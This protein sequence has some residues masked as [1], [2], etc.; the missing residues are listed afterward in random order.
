[1]KERKWIVEKVNRVYVSIC[2][3][4]VFLNDGFDTFTNDY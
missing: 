4:D 2:A 3:Y 1:M